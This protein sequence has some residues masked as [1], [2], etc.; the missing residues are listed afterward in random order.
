MKPLPTR[1]LRSSSRLRCGILAIV[2]L[3]APACGRPT[4]TE[5]LPDP[6]SAPAPGAT[7]APAPPSSAA[8]SPT[9]AAAPPPGPAHFVET[10]DVSVFQRGNLH[11]HTSR[12]DGD[13][14]P[15]DSYTWYRDHGYAFVAITDHNQLTPPEEYQSLGRKGFAMIPGEEITML[16]QGHP[17]HVNALCTQRTIG[18]VPDHALEKIPTIDAALRWAVS[19]VLEQDGV[20]LVNHPNFIWALTADDLPSAHGAQLLEIWSGHPYVRS[21]GDAQHPSEET[22]WDRVLKERETFAGVAVDDTHYIGPHKSPAARPGRGWVEVFAAEA[23]V[24][25]I[26]AA[27]AKG[28]LYSSSGVRLRRIAVTSDALSLWPDRP[29]ALVEFVGEGGEVLA[30]TRP[31]AGASATYKLRGGERYVRARATLPDGKHA[32]TQPYQV[33]PEVRP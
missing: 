14:P 10:L 9:V 29:G 19:R 2:T 1:M 6:A 20:A 3:G 7:S 28:H 16:V 12:S 25:A 17:V 24:P 23:T 18:D 32:W 8:P 22:I 31:P 33:A 5:A 15:E 13:R 26:C 30:R 11:T 4:R 21:D 27:L